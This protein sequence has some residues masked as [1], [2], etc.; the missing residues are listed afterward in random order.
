MKIR[1]SFEAAVAILLAAALAACGG[2]AGTLNVQTQGVRVGTAFV[3]GTDAPLGS[4]LAFRITLTG[5][6]VSDGTNTASLLSQ[7]SD[8]EFARLNGLRA[9]IDMR[10]VPAGTYNS[11][12]ATLASPVISFLDTSTTPPSVGTINGTLTRSSVAVQLNPPLT[13]ADGDL[14][15]LLMDF[16]LASSLERDAT[17]QLTGNVTP[18]I[19]FRVIPPNAPEAEIDELRGG[20]VSVNVAAGTFVMQGPHGRTLTVSTDANTIFE[21]GEDLNSLTTS[22]VV[23]VSGSIQRGSLNLRA[24]SVQIVSDDRFVLGGLITDARPAS[25]AADFVD[26]L[27]RTELPDIAGVRPGAIATL[28][29]DGNERFMIHSFRMPLLHF[30]FNRAALLPGQRIS[31]GGQLITSA[32]PPSLDV[33][34]VTLHRQGLEGGWVV[35]STHGSGKN[36]SFNFRATGLTG[37]LF[38]QAVRVVTSDRTRFINLTDLGDLSGSNP[39]ALRVVGLVLKEPVTG[40]PVIIAWA[41]ER[42]APQSP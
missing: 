23:E 31:A 14:I 12:T 40:N 34:R 9:L 13:V 1:R 26:L 30:L 33:R 27:V 15:G 37:M 35:G 4:V 5:L 38:G 10:S 8:F 2:G 17:G 11:L 3:V 32:N 6:S 16:R 41:V 39:I 29:F 42:M 36:G 7:P 28:G 25:G 18:N 19:L 20:V 22:S 24:T 21:T